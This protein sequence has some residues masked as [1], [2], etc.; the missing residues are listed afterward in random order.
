MQNK[1]IIYSLFLF[2]SSTSLAAK[3]QN[4]IE[5]LNLVRSNVLRTE[6]MLIKTLKD[7]NQNTQKLIHLRKLLTLQREEQ[8]L[9]NERIKELKTYIQQME[10]RKSELASHV[11][12]QQSVLRDFLEQLNQSIDRTPKGLPFSTS[13]KLEAPKRVV[14]ARMVQRGMRI[15]EELK[16]D[17]A[18]VEYLEQKI[19]KEKSELTYFVN[20]SKERE[21]LLK[22]HK[23][24]QIDLFQNNYHQR[25][26]QLES[27]QDL[28]SAEDQVE[29]LIKQFN[30]RTEF[31]ELAKE[32]EKKSS[33][34]GE[35]FAKS[36]GKL[37]WPIEGKVLSGFGRRFDSLSKLYVFKKGIEI[38]NA[39][40][41]KVKNV[42]PGKVVYS[43]E[44]AS[45]GKVVIVDHGQN[46][47]SLIA[48]LG[49][50]SLAV[51]DWV[52]AGQAIGLSRADGQAVYFEIRS[53]SVALNPLKW[54]SN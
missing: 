12:V 1:V 11:K 33:V 15:L 39:G 37:L 6:K 52:N 14:I 9:A 43:G 10:V 16:A 40:E 41:Q 25:V 23:K 20:E 13:E 3:K 35:T 34:W 32:E 47:F 54:M 18:D 48:R 4:L 28:K 21:S 26:T 27:Y 42:F 50:K 51:G 38:E 5:E 17:V 31:A 2:L 53:G 45:Y 7:Q 46:Y 44:L 30:V 29:K 8:K 36:K 24:L 49:K 22:F 19:V